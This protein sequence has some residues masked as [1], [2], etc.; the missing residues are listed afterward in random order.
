MSLTEYNED[1]ILAGLDFEHY[2]S[3]SDTWYPVPNITDVGALGEQAEKKEKTN[4]SDKVKK[5]GSGMQDAPDKAV[6]GQYI[7]LQ[8]A[9]SVYAEEY[10]DQQRFIKRCRNREEFM[11]RVKWASGEVNSFLF[12]ALGFEFDSPNQAEWKMF[13]ANGSQNTRMCWGIDITGDA[14]VATGSSTSAL[15]AATD[16]IDLDLNDDESFTWSSE[17]ETIATVDSVTGIVTGVAAGTV[18]I[19]AEIRGVYGYHEVTVS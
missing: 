7:P 6:K 8:S 15:T 17:D 14:S 9:T 13:T 4:L 1:V 12:K 10:E 5:Y 16:P 11:V 2:D 19:V 18:S 3:T